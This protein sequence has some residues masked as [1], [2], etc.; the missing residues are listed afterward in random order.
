MLLV[1]GVLSLAAAEFGRRAGRHDVHN[2]GLLLSSTPAMAKRERDGEC[3]GAQDDDSAGKK[4]REGVRCDGTAEDPAFTLR[5]RLGKGTY[6]DV[7]YVE[8]P[9]GQPLAL[10]LIRATED[11]DAT[12]AF[13]DLVREAYGLSKSGLLRGILCSPD[14]MRGAVLMPLFGN[15]LGTVFMERYRPTVV[16]RLMHTV[17]LALSKFDGIH[18]DVKPSN[19]LLPTPEAFAAGHG[20][21]LVDFSLCT[22]A[23]A[24]I[25]TAVVTLW[26]RPVEVLVGAVQS[27]AVD[28]W[29]LGAVLLAMLSGSHFAR[30]CSENHKA[31]LVLDILDH[32]GWPSE[33]W[34]EL[35]RALGEW[36]GPLKVRRG[37]PV[38]LLDVGSVIRRS[39][40]EEP[41]AAAAAA[42]LLE[43]ML[44]VRPEARIT[45]AEAAKHPFWSFGARSFEGGNGMSAKVTYVSEV[46]AHELKGFLEN[47]RITWWSGSCAGPKTGSTGSGAGPASRATLFATSRVRLYAIDHLKNYGAKMGFSTSTVFKAYR[48]WAC[49][50]ANKANS[51]VYGLAASLFLAACMT[52]D[53]RA[54]PPKWNEWSSMWDCNGSKGQK[55]LAAAVDVLMRSQA[56]WPRE[57]LLGAIQGVE[58][59]AKADLELLPPWAP[60]FLTT[61]NDPLD[62]TEVRSLAAVLADILDNEPGSI[63]S[64]C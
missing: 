30:P 58:K 31:H 61:A 53:I 12:D 52:E 9:T 8:S 14:G 23:D 49:A 16:A 18:R 32:F 13:Q 6:G 64:K 34:P 63:V 4:G 55:V 45:W 37:S 17:V 21:M 47:A 46:D 51:T 24:S 42:D 44:R 33:A 25:D 39:W 19:I 35:D 48:I 57:S 10:K 54:K 56:T 11:P 5:G 3:L 2:C 60:L 1:A 36:F 50:V 41:E 59:V 15:R 29:S 28:V 20:A 26:Y 7:Y 43:R 40:P 27:P 38:G 22:E 62:A